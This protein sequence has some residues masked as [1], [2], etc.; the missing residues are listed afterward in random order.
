[1]Y[2][3][4]IQLVL[5]VQPRLHLDVAVCKWLSLLVSPP[6]WPHYQ[7]TPITAL[8]CTALHCS[9]LQCT[10]LHYIALLHCNIDLLYYQ[11][12]LKTPHPF[13]ILLF[14]NKGTFWYT[15]TSYGYRPRQL[16]SALLLKLVPASRLQLQNVFTPTWQRTFNP[17]PLQSCLP[18]S[19]IFYFSFLL[20]STGPPQPSTK[21]CYSHL[22]RLLHST[23]F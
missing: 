13:S 14:L 3:I 12:F 8:H 15:I 5:F 11:T 17:Y 18:L 2:H 20:H 1:M 22:S 7:V 21:D 10:A 9:V 16:V 23:H 19:P 6:Q 4:F